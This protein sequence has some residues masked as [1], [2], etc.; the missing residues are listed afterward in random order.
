M[1]HNAK[2]SFTIMQFL[3]W[4]SWATFGQFYTF[5]LAEHQYTSAQIG[6][7]MTFFMIMGLIGQYVWGLFS[8]YQQSV[9]KSYMACVVLLAIFAIA[10]GVF[11]EHP[12]LIY[13]IVGGLGFAF[14]PKEALIDGWI[15]G[16]DEIRQKDYGKIRAAGSLGYAL[17]CAIF[18]KIIHLYG[19]ST[20]F[21]AFVF[22]AAIDLFFISQVKDQYKKSIHLKN[23]HPLQL[24]KDLRY[25]LLILFVFLI[26]VGNLSLL[27]FL[28]F[29]L[30]AVGGNEVH[31]GLAAA[32]AAAV[33]I[34]IFI[35][36]G[37]FIGKIQPNKI[38]LLAAVAYV[39]RVT[40][41]WIATGPTLVIIASGLQA[42]GFSMT[43]SMGRIFIS[44]IAPGS[45]KTTAQTLFS[46]SFFGIAG[47]VAS[48]VGGYII[49]QYGMNNLFI[50]SEIFVLMGFSLMVGINIFGK[51]EDLSMFH[52]STSE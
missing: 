33:E 50:F 7:A 8:D 39:L 30:K 42:I 45:L 16:T 31:L 28:P 40:V 41:T 49:E 29:I 22:I 48:L 36:S 14:M 20:M 52:S 17:V 21:Y 5:Y 19:W 43:L 6:I 1:K 44:K 47:I 4:S 34:P 15:L 51:K 10:F 12:L 18:G 38:F 24:F 32:L 9:K 23:L 2:R 25:S 37:K 35:L 27:N 3:L 13:F 11:S 26:H 46:A